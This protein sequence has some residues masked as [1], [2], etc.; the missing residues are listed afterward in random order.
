MAELARVGD[1]VTLTVV[2]PPRTASATQRYVARQ[3]GHSPRL[4]EPDARGLLRGILAGR[5]RVGRRPWLAAL[6]MLSR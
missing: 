1:G 2:I 4:H 5:R 3:S 6:A